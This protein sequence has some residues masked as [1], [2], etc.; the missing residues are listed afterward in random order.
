[1]FLS[2]D[3]LHCL[4]IKHCMKAF[5]SCVNVL[6]RLDASAF[7]VFFSVFVFA[8][9]LVGTDTADC[10]QSQ[11]VLLPLGLFLKL[12]LYVSKRRVCQRNSTHGHC[13]TQLRCVRQ[14]ASIHEHCHTL[15]WGVS[16][17]QTAYM[18]TV[19]HLF[20][21]CT[22]IKI[23]HSCTSIVTMRQHTDLF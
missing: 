9:L 1:M 8:F 18:N 14:T 13:D 21:L 20:V 15:N 7:P 3:P 12:L 10:N 19:T 5:Y 16:D 17:R 2:A 23:T 6:L 11:V 22:V 4:F